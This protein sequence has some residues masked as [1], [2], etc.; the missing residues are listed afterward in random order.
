MFGIRYLKSPATMYVQ[1]YS[2]GRIK[3][4]GTGLAFYYFAPRSVIVQL[5]VSSVDVPFA[6]TEATADFQDATLQGNLTYRVSDPQRLAKLL[7]YTIG[8]NGRYES[9]DPSKLG[10]R[11]VQAAQIGAR[12]FIHRQPLRDV[13]VGSAALVDAMRQSLVESP[14]LTQLGIEALEVAI[15]SIDA[16]PEM[17]KALGGAHD[18]LCDCFQ[19]AFV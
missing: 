19:A 9:D 14:T 5:P 8:R 17:T 10:E 4:E 1:H 13:L 18:A 16:D 15:V 2:G 3:Q 11:L 12:Q 7:N 6:F